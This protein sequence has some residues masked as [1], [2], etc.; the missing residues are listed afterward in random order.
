[1]IFHPALPVLLVFMASAVA[2]DDASS[3]GLEQL[4]QKL[5]ANP[6]APVQ[7]RE[8]RRLAAIDAPVVTRGVLACTPPGRL[9]RET[10]E[11]HT[12]RYVLDGETFSIERDIEG[13]RVRREFPLAGFP[14]LRAYLLAIRATLAGDRTTLEGLYD[15]GL[16][17]TADAW[18]LRLRPRKDRLGTAVREIRLHGRGAAV[19]RID[20]D[21]AGGDTTRMVLTPVEPAPGG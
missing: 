17:G 14:P 3:F 9:E 11:P 7:F 6:P 18:T 13:K 4:A 19:E 2:A 16:T 8:E 20:S 12:E 21:E 5:A 1:M 15:V 10:R